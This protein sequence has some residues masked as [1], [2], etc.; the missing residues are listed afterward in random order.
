MNNLHI[1][2]IE[3]IDYDGFECMWVRLTCGSESRKVCFEPTTDGRWAYLDGDI[4]PLMP[5]EVRKE[6][7]GKAGDEALQGL[8]EG[9]F[10]HTVIE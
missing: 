7:H 8:W 9:R 1:E 3:K 6:W 4:E 2:L 5:D 10:T